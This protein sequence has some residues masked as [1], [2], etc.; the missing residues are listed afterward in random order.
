MSDPTT[1]PIEPIQP[2]GDDYPVDDEPVKARRSAKGAALVGVR[3]VAGAVGIA[4]A[5]SAIAVAALVPLPTIE[6]EPLAVTVTPVPTA[7]ELVCPGSLLRLGD[8]T[9]QDASTASP[10]GE[11]RVRYGATG[12]EVTASPVAEA[13]APGSPFLVSSP[14]GGASDDDVLVAGAQSQVADSSDFSGLA[15]AQCVGVATETWLVGGSTAVGR[16][17]LVT[18]ANPSDT[19]STVSLA[20]ASEVGPVV[21]PGATGIVVQP[22]SQRVLS[23]A[24][25]APDVQSPVVHVESRGGQIVANLQQA[26]VRGLEAGGVEVIGATGSP[27]T[28]HIVP[29]VVVAGAGTLATRLGEDGYA[30]LGTVVRIYVPGDEPTTARVDV[31]AD[32]G[33]TPGASFSVELEPGVVDDLPIDGLVDGNYTVSVETSVPVVASVRVSTAAASADPA[34]QGATDFAWL[35]AAGTLRDEALVTVAAG[36]FPRIHLYNPSSDDAD[37]TLTD[38]DGA[39]YELSVPAGSSSSFAASPGATYDIEGFDTLFGAVS[40][41]GGGIAGYVVRPPAQSAGP[42]RVLP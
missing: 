24:G 3:V 37:A 28:S 15:A 19:V 12:G 42:I 2:V 13:G 26:T 7:Q 39:V 32:D 25:F 34:V 5:A 17:T 35:A 31:T 16:T 33:T 41:S 36:P 23:L 38:I 22:H 9:G 40:Y 27:A 21:A 8:E 29:G 14:V 20:I 10:I 30:D 18:L 6:A 1:D 4:V 11:A